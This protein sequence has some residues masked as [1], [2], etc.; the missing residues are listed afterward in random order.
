M[1]INQSTIM[2]AVGAVAGL[3]VAKKL[4]KG[5]RAGM[6][7]IGA[8]AA[9]TIVGKMAGDKIAQKQLAASSPYGS[10]TAGV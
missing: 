2:T 3:L 7:T 1:N 6:A 4:A 10:V 5:K 9:G 8:V